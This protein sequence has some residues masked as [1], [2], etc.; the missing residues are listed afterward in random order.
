MKKLSIFNIMIILCFA[1][2][3][4]E[5]DVRKKECFDFDWK[6]NLGDVEESSVSGYN[7]VYWEKIQLPHDWSIAL[8][9]DS[10]MT[11]GRQMG[12]LPGGISWYR[13]T[14]D[15]PI[16]YKGKK[17]YIHFDGVYHQSDVYINGKHLG[18]YPYGYIDFE[19]DLTPYLNYGGKNTVAVR[20]DHSNYPSSRWYSGSGIYRH[21]WFIV[22]DPVHIPSHGTYVTTPVITK[23]SADVKIV[24]TIKNTTSVKRNITL[25]S[26]IVDAGGNVVAV[27]TVPV[28]VAKN[29]TI[30]VAQTIQAPNPVLWSTVTPYLYCVESLVK[31]DNRIIDRYETVFGIRYFHYDPDKGF[32]LNGENLKM[33]GMNLHQDAGSL[34]TAVPD[35]SHE[36]KLTIL[37]EYGCNAIRCSHNPPSPEFLDACDRLGFLVI[38]E[39]FDKWKSRYYEKYFDRWWQKDLDGM[40]LRDRNHPSIIMWSIG[41]EVSEQ[42]DTT[43]TGTRRAE[44]LQN[45]V[46]QVEPTRPVMVAIAPGNL[47]IRPYNKSGFTEIMDIVGYNYQEPWY[48]DDKEMFPNRIMFGAEVFPYFRGRKENIRGYFPINPW[49]DVA[50]NDFIFGQFLWA[51]VDYLGESS[52]WPSKG[53]PTSPFDI[54]MFEKP[55]AA[56]HRSV[57]NNQPM[58]RIAVMDQSLNIDPGKDHWSSPF[59]VAH[60]NFPQYTGHIIQV[61]T[62][63]NCEAV[64]L[65]VNGTSLGKRKTA[66]YT[67]N[68]IVWY[69]PYNAGKIRATGYN[70]QNETAH[71]ELMTSGKPAKI[72]LSADREIIA[73]DGQDISHITVTIV[74]DIG[75]VVPDHDLKITFNVSGNGNLLGLDNGDLRSNEPFKG[76]KRTTCFGKMLAIVQSSRNPGEITIKASGEGL[77]EREIRIICK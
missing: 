42:N 29:K 67:N 60:W 65:W 50:N 9:F 77:P 19:Y 31:A 41:N 47:S 51:G 35:R 18:F 71:D 45:R 2:Y 24:T 59:M 46:H 73:A 61:Q 43:G 21:V 17:V 64:E 62:I 7:D 6:F 58:V 1:A 69:V 56:F 11:N 30:D 75:I 38:D 34:G 76:N 49:Y 16:A 70:N 12:F 23:E 27:A 28:S 74:D 3:A 25:E 44:M 53:W 14:F 66:D 63:T 40:L 72:V 52:G 15:I 26:R 54:C 55:M 8:P 33:K 22:T 57:W 36:R 32:F 4:Q 37:K 13:K 48:I 68:T 20:V 39:A 5:I 10:A